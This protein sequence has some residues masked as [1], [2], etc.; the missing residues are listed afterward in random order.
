MPFDKPDSA[1]LPDSM[2]IINIPFNEPDIARKT[3]QDHAKE[4]AGVIVEPLLGVGGIVPP[5]PG[6]LETLRE[7]TTN[8]DACLIFDEVVTGFNIALGGG[9]E[10]FGVIPDLA[11][12]GKTLGGGAHMSAIGGSKELM[13]ITNPLRPGKKYE[14]VGMGGGTFSS[15]LPSLFAAY[16]NL[17]YLKEN[18]DTI[19]PQ[20]KR[21]GDRMRTRI[22]E[23]IIPNTKLILKCTG[24]ASASGFHFLT[25]DVPPI[26]AGNIEGNMH[27]EQQTEY[28]VRMLNDGIHTM[29][30]LG[31]LCTEHGEFD[32]ET[33][34]T[35]IGTA[36][37]AIEKS[38]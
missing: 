9:Q 23:E 34:I 1:G 33:T 10:F 13:S 16:E 38:Y 25:K 6:Y 15:Y 20:L 17:T 29:H 36:I 14:K 37:D 21:F 35:A 4:L 11:V 3:I 2:D 18:K 22:H 31:R 5:E 8:V 32:I 12:Y 26:N 28:F 27:N 7:E 30:G 24:V 19:Y